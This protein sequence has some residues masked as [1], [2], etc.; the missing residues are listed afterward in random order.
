[1]N[2]IRRLVLRAVAREIA[3]RWVAEARS[4][5]ALHNNGL[6]VSG[7]YN[8]ACAAK[9]QCARDLMGADWIPQNNAVS[10]G[11]E[12]RTLDGLAGG[13]VD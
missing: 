6:M 2:P 11:A 5:A 12:R 3:E 13:K 1:M 8:A 9:E 10:G 4:D 7:M